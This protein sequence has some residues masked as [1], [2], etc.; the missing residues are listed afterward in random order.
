MHVPCFHFPSVSLLASP[1]RAEL[2]GYGGLESKVSVTV[3]MVH[4]G[5]VNRARYCPQNPFVIATKSPSNDVLLFD[6]STHPS[7]PA[8]GD[9]EC[10]PQ[11]RLKGHTAEGYGLSWS[12]LDEGRILS[13]SDDKTVILWDTK[14]QAGKRGELGPTRVFEGHTAVVEDVQ[15]HRHHRDL[16][17]S[18]GDDRCLILWDARD[19]SARPSNIIREAHNG[20]INC[21]SFNPFH[22]FLF[23]TGGADKV[24]V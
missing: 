10:H 9:L 19:S 2:G 8:D 15:W 6:Y 18:V 1:F 17:A 12:S 20:E 7:K 14:G 3:K 21:L 5:E 11:L 23:V 22:E 13:G 24:R 16:F 4:D